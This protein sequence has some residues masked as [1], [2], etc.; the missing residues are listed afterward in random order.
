MFS[1]L[2]WE[3]AI[4]C[5]VYGFT[6]EEDGGE[7]CESGKS[8]DRELGSGFSL[9]FIIQRIHNIREDGAGQ[10]DSAICGREY[11]SDENAGQKDSDGMPELRR[12]N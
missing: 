7:D 3:E 5:K 10:S 4:D 1:D 11:G 6:A 12:R 2:E 8:G 9:V